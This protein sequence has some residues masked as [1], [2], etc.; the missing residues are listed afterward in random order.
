MSCRP[1]FLPG[2]EP[3]LL[4][5]ERPR[6]RR[7]DD[8]QAPDIRDL[9]R[10]RS[11]PDVP[12]LDTSQPR[13][14][15]TSGW[16]RRRRLNHPRMECPRRGPTRVAT[17]SVVL[18][19]SRLASCFWGHA[20]GVA[21]RAG[22]FGSVA[23][24]R[25]QRQHRKGVD[26]PRGGAAAGRQA[27]RRS[28]Q[29]TTAG[30][31]RPKRMEAAARATETHGSADGFRRFLAFGRIIGQNARKRPDRP[32]LTC[33]SA[34]WAALSC[35]SAIRSALTCVWANRSVGSAAQAGELGTTPSP[36]L[37]RCAVPL[38]RR[39]RTA[40]GANF[41]SIASRSAD[42]DVS[43]TWFADQPTGEL[44]EDR[45]RGQWPKRK[46]VDLAFAAPRA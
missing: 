4:D 27:P 17:S 23:G 12:P 25:R 20:T 10:A 13:V 21:G 7:V 29:R 15:V 31:L 34:I 1:P 8:A 3:D 9:Q 32:A 35:V 38:S 39:Q 36:P 11:S 2:L 24:D 26:W 28:P 19:R 22:A 30:L 43:S 40:E 14:T 18:V 42:Q 45:R 16:L 46:S 44:G 41:R 33:V 5:Q 37:L 6:G